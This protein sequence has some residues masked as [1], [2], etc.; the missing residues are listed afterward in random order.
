MLVLGFPPLLVHLTFQNRREIFDWTWLWEV[1][2]IVFLR[3]IWNVLFSEPIQC[4]FR[5]VTTC[6]VRPKH[7]FVLSMFP[8]DGLLHF[9]QTLVD[10]NFGIDRF[11][12]TWSNNWWWNTFG[13]NRQPNQHLRLK[14]CFFRIFYIVWSLF[15]VVCI[16]AIIP[17]QFMMRKSEVRFIIQNDEFSIC[18][19]FVSKCTA[20]F[21]Y[22]FEL[23]GWI[24]RCSLTFT[25]GNI[26]F[27]QN[28][29]ECAVGNT[30]FPP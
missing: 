19:V 15:R 4:F 9:R 23:P 29:V 11:C 2:R 25:I 27:R 1:W 22:Y 20:A 18:K 10:I 7:D 16:I 24:F 3:Y 12:T 6:Q 8:F 28:A 13:L 17:T 26:I 14:L 21:R 5:V 30:K